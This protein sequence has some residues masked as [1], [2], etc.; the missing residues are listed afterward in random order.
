MA[1]DIIAPSIRGKDLK[2]AFDL[3][4]RRCRTRTPESRLAKKAST[5]T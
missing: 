3:A 5:Q 2:A 4:V 1:M